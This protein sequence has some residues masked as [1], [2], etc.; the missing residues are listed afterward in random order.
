MRAET[1]EIPSAERV[2]ASPRKTV[3]VRGSGNSFGMKF[4]QIVR[5]RPI[6]FSRPSTALSYSAVGGKLY[7]VF[8]DD[9]LTSGSG[10]SG[11]APILRNCV[12][13]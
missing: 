8:H 13:Q 12:T 11:I 4:S 10:L 3:L 1:A 7:R 9:A 6:G 5:A 2:C